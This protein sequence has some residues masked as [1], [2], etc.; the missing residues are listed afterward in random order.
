VQNELPPD[1]VAFDL[2]RGSEIE[3]ATDGRFNLAAATASGR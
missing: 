2:L 3:R 1:S